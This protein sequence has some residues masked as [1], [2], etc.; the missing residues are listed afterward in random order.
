[1]SQ[2][3]FSQLADALDRLPN[4]FPRTEAGTEIALLKR[5]FSDEE[6]EIAA[7]LSGTP[8][9][10]EAIAE[11][12]GQSVKDARGRLIKMARQGLVW[13]IKQDGKVR[14][15]LAP[16]VVGIYE[17]A[18]NLVDEEFAQLFEDYMAGGG[19]KAILGLGVPL[20][21][22]VP[23]EE[24]VDP[25]WVL[26]YDDVRS[27]LMKAE[28]FN[29]QD[30]ICRVQQGKIGHECEFPVHTCLNF[31]PVKRGPRPGDISREEA[32]ALLAKAAE[33]GLV[34]SVS[35]NQEVGY[36]CNCCGCCCALLRGINEWGIEESVAYANYYAVLNEEKCTECG[37]CVRRC[38]VN[39]IERDEGLPTVV[40]ERCIGCGVCVTGCRAGALR[41][42]LKPESEIVAPPIDYATWEGLR[43]TERQQET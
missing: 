29:V 9:S 37:L 21:R 24:T 25:E 35:N 13:L 12:M 36:V 15:R 30:C 42:Q 19:G 14:F 3:T 10:A 27:I 33:Q 4:R 5:I 2:D 40:C 16:F 7:G 31:S 17:A 11:R 39:A 26:P 6:A 23:A 41:M 28:V 43:E 20:Q 18:L 32:L 22:V 8:E 34:H 1:M 38:Q